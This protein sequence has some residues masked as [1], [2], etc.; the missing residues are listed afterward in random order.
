MKKKSIILQLALVSVITIFGQTKDNR[1]GINAGGTIQQYNGNLGSSFFRFNTTCFAG[2]K[3]TAGL[4]LNNSFDLN[5]SLFAGQFGY[6][7]TEADKNRFVSLNYRCPGCTDRIGMG[8][9]RSLMLASVLSVKYKFSNGYILKENSKLSPYLAV[10]AGYNRLID[11]M[12]RQCV[13]EGSHFSL[14]AGTGLIYN[15][16]DK[17]NFGYT[18]NLSCFMPKKVY[19]TNEMSAEPETEPMDLIDIKLE[20]RKDLCLQHSIIIGFNF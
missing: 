12:K 14:N 19:L 13:T 7:Q 2:A 1:F 10:G 15:I 4:Y 6:C 17:L 3:T 16:T 8:E 9:L 18:A 11:N 20:R 5:L